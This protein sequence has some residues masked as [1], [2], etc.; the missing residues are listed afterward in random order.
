MT[1]S[2]TRPGM[3]AAYG[4]PLFA[5]VA[6][7][8]KWVCFCHAGRNATTNDP[9]TAVLNAN[10][11]IVN[12]VV[13]IRRFGYT[14]EWATVK[15]GIAK[16]LREANRTDLLP[17]PADCVNGNQP[18]MRVWLRRLERE[19]ITLTSGIGEQRTFASTIPTA[20]IIGPTHV[21]Q[22]YTEPQQ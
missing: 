21:M 17:G 13:D 6:P 14:D 11:H 7:D 1:E 10:A 16:A 22:H 2:N 4:C 8:G 15:R 12:A 5:T 9:V 20:P 3:C 18:E 19:L